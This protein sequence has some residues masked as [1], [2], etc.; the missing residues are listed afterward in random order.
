MTVI[1]LSVSAGAPF[2]YQISSLGNPEL[3]FAENLPN[4]WTCSSTGLITG[5]VPSARRFVVTI[6]AKNKSGVTA[7][8]LD[9]TT[10]VPPPPVIG[11][12]ETVAA[13]IGVAFSYQIVATSGTAITSYSA[14]NLPPWMSLNTVTG[15][16]T[17]TANVTETRTLLVGATNANGTATKNI[18]LRSAQRPTIT[19]PLTFSCLKNSPASYQIVASA[20]PTS[21][22][23]SG[24]PDGLALN[25]STGLISGTPTTS[26]S[27]NV[28]LT[29]TNLV[30]TSNPV[31]L[32]VTVSQLLEITSSL[33][34][35]ATYN[36]A[37]SYQI[38]TSGS[39]APISYN[40]SPLPSG[41]S[42]NTS[43]GVISGTVNMSYAAPFNVTLS[44]TNAVGTG[45]ATLVL[46]I[47]NLI[48]NVSPDSITVSSLGG[49]PTPTFNKYLIVSRTKAYES[50]DKVNWTS[51]GASN[52]NATNVS[53]S[54]VSGAP[55]KLL[56][57]GKLVLS[58][59]GFKAESL[60]FDARHQDVVSGVSYVNGL[61]TDTSGSPLTYSF[62]G[63]PTGNVPYLFLNPND[64][65]NATNKHY[66][67][68]AV[69][70]ITNDFSTAPLTADNKVRAKYSC[71]FSGG[72]YGVLPTSWFALFNAAEGS[73]PGTSN[74]TFLYGFFPANYFGNPGPYGFAQAIGVS[75]GVDGRLIISG[76]RKAI[77]LRNRLS[78]FG[79]GAANSA[80]TW[81]V[82]SD[83]ITISVDQ[84]GPNPESAV[85]VGQRLSSLSNPAAFEPLTFVSGTARIPT[86]GGGPDTLEAYVQP[87]ALITNTN[88]NNT[89][90]FANL[91]NYT[92]GGLIEGMT[93]R[94][95]WQVLSDRIRI[96]GGL[97][98]NFISPGQRVIISGVSA[99]GFGSGVLADP[100][101][102]KTFAATTGNNEYDIFLD[103][104]P[105]TPNTN[106]IHIIK[107]YHP[108]CQI[109]IANKPAKGGPNGV[110]ATDSL[111]LVNLAYQGGSTTASQINDCGY[112]GINIDGGRGYDQIAQNLVG[113]VIVVAGG[114]YA[115]T[116]VSGEQTMAYSTNYGATWTPI[117]PAPASSFNSSNLYY[118]EPTNKF[119]VRYGS[120][121]YSSSNGSSWALDTDPG[122]DAPGFPPRHLAQ[123]ILENQF[124]L[125]RFL[126]KVYVQVKYLG[127]ENCYPF[128]VAISDENR[129]NWTVS[130]FNS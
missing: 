105:L 18:I 52:L 115:S 47:E 63:S 80:S 16:L 94:N 85:V 128:Q 122:T 93:I 101:Y 27:F 82:Y 58:A 73:L 10:T 67:F 89:I 100:C 112:V 110:N 49:S 24:L 45:T 15:L 30:F 102:V 34:A 96:N 117:E 121:V 130:T 106:P 9:I 40:A 119:Y 78:P 69:N 61:V 75:N 57:A 28:V 104:P 72:S 41:L 60:F 91:K 98:L 43:S 87:P 99:P 2:S 50:S 6:F 53:Q 19:S 7:A 68:G 71:Y 26:G 3:F 56:G 8:V 5:T 129:T 36:V 29:A 127:V 21:Y 109:L 118:F 39:P 22:T 77:H 17:G 54:S 113:D 126:P 107:F 11:G 1:Y 4:G 86:P 51:S 108:S 111:G 31:T 64:K 55:N 116:K 38:T 84:L 114:A 65:T 62:P 74:G 92:C 120:S 14:T 123:Y 37:F 70:C 83:K 79:R 33:T 12:S 81:R 46:S 20:N 90:G 76:R 35:T 97:D 125:T 66:L 103:P 13:E 59:D 124:L 48:A 42:I 88:P 23:A 95:S 25:T 32:V 44:A